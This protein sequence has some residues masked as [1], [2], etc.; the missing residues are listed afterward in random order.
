MR[1]VPRSLSGPILK[2]SAHFPVL[3][4]TGPR[5]SGKTTLLR[6][7][8][9][10]AAYHLLE[11]P[12]IIGRVRQDPRSFLDSIRLPVILDEIQHLPELFPY[13][14]SRV[15]QGGSKAKGWYLTGSQEPPLMR[16]VTESMAGRAAIFQLLPFSCAESPRVSPLAG[17]FPEALG[18][19]RLADVWFRSYLQTYLEKDV[20]AISSIRS[21][22]TFRRF[23]AL[24]AAR[25]G[26]VLNRSDLAA[27]LGVSVPTIS[28]WLNILEATHQI[29]LVPPY[30]ENFGKRLIKSPKLYFGD[31]GLAA[32]LLGLET[33]SQ[34]ER[35]PFWGPLFEN[36]VAVEI[37]KAQI[38]AGRRKDL[39]F[40][41][42]R[43]GLEVDFLVPQKGGGLALVEAKATRTVRPET[44]DPMARLAGSI[45]GQRVESYI[46]HLPSPTGPAFTSVR[47]GVKAKTYLE[48]SEIAL[49]AR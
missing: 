14:R 10:G 8:L 40:F 28:E 49:A 3:I 36:F 18:R 38:N 6:K 29:L 24:A 30:F 11:D 33:S 9:P 39:Y 27:P 2:A 5:R 23:L 42:D 19:P 12:D 22:A 34:L 41:R 45:S 1:Y 7:M 37:V 31:T 21:L 44:A 17:G 43:Q 46:V 26:Q 15:D 16:G 25:I 48:I 32:Y 4:V 20:R 13:I 35:S 47:P